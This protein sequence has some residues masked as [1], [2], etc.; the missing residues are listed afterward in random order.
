MSNN[1]IVVFRLGNQ[2]Y[3]TV[4]TAVSGM[5]SQVQD[6]QALRSNC[7]PLMKIQTGHTDFDGRQALLLSSYG[8]QVALLVDEVI[9]VEDVREIKQLQEPAG[10]FHIWRIS[11]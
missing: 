2:Y 8:V 3:G 4:S 6:I 7:I 11:G 1:R 9:K 10:V 5:A